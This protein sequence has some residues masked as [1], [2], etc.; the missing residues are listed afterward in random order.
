MIFTIGETVLDI[1]FKDLTDVKVRPGGSMLNTAIS[2]G[3]LG[4]QVNHITTLSGDRSADLLIEFLNQNGVGTQWILRDREIKTSLALAYLDKEQKAEYTF[5]KDEL[6]KQP[7]L[8]F[9]EIKSDDII[10][11]G[12]F[13]SL[14]P[15]I[16]SQLSGFLSKAKHSGALIIYDPNFRKPHLPQLPQFLPYINEN[17]G[18]AHLVKASDE[19]FENIFNLTNGADAWG[20]A[21]LTGVKALIYTKGDQGAELFSS[22]YHLTVPGIPVQVVST[23]GAGD[24]FSAGL[25]YALS[26][27]NRHSSLSEMDK[28]KWSATIHFANRCAACVCEHFDNYLPHDTIEE[29]KNVQ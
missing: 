9:P 11:F 19:D 12:S 18:F 6:K 14:N 3:R 21:K 17:F 2:L 13:F 24:T 23:I 8:I 22:D 26:S 25:I 28:S 16:R 1:I 4:L 20:K 29:L 15:N 7:E 27:G 10:L 5:Y